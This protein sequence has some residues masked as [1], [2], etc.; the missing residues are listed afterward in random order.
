MFNDVDRAVGGRSERFVDYDSYSEVDRAACELNVRVV[1]GRNHNQVVVSGSLENPFRRGLDPDAGIGLS[2]GLAPTAV[3]GDH[4][5]ELESVGG[6]DQW[7]MKYGPGEPVTD[8][9]SPQRRGQRA[10]SRR[11]RVT[12]SMITAASRT[13]P[14]IM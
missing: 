9:R 5:R 12:A 14:V 3:A 2:R 7:C 10:C 4:G 8:Q 13:A 11:W 6:A 1:G